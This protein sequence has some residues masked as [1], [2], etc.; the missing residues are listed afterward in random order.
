[1][2]EEELI[3]RTKQ[4]RPELTEE[5]NKVL[6]SKKEISERVKNL[7]IAIDIE[8]GRGTCPHHSELLVVKTRRSD[9]G[10]FYGCPT[11]SVTGCKYTENPSKRIDSIL[12]ELSRFF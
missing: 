8:T 3:Q 11:Y 10:V 2:N 5:D 1:M 12:D 6:E 9:N 7:I 4:R